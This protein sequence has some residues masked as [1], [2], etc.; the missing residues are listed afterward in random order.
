MSLRGRPDRIRTRGEWP[1]R[2]ELSMG[3]ARAI[4]RPWNDHVAAAAL[5]LERGGVRFLAGSAHLVASWSPEV[6]SPATL[7]SA[8]RIW[9]EAGFVVADRLVLLEHGLNRLETPRHPIEPGSLEPLEELYAIDTDSFDPKWRL[10]RMG[11]A[12]SVA[13]TSRAVV[14]R[15]RD[16]GICVGFAVNG[17]AMGVGYLQR[18]AVATDHRNM[19]IG[20][21]L[22]RASLRWA[23]GRG[24]HSMLVNTQVDNTPAAGL[25][26]G[27]GFNDVPGGLLVLRYEPDRKGR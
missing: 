6:L 14:L 19:G 11:M 9:V 24:A 1:G 21:D 23:R 15:A 27:L 25:Y 26:R 17:V 8:T 2:V 13:A 7:P 12:E 18:L 20:T 5:R 10:G 22:V 3:W 4:A 16:N